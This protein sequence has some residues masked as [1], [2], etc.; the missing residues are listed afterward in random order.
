MYSEFICTQGDEKNQRRNQTE[1]H[2]WVNGFQ[3]KLTRMSCPGTGECFLP[4]SGDNHLNMAGRAS[5]QDTST[6]NGMAG[7]CPVMLMLIMLVNNM[8]ARFIEI[9]DH[10]EAWIEFLI[11]FATGRFVEVSSNLCP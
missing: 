7:M 6:R 10:L 2:D 1:M 4:L 8:P 3:E 9:V 11:I 5:N